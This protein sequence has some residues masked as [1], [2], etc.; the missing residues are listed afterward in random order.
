[1]VKK[2]ITRKPKKG[3]VRKTRKIVKKSRRVMKGGTRPEGIPE[4]D[5]PTAKRLLDDIGKWR[6]I[7]CLKY[8]NGSVMVVEDSEDVHDVAS[9]DLIKFHKTILENVLY[10]YIIFREPETGKLQI[11]LTPFQTPEIGTKHMCLLLGIDEDAEVIASGELFRKGD[12]VSYSCMSSLFFSHMLKQL[13][14]TISY[15]EKSKVNPRKKLIDDAREYYEREEVLKYMKEV[16]PK[17]YTIIYA[18]KFESSIPLERKEFRP[19]EFCTL[20]EG[21]RPSCLRYVTDKEC[22]TLEEHPGL[23]YCEAGVDFCSNLD[24]DTPPREGIPEEAYVYENKFDNE[25]A[26][27]F[28]LSQ[29]KTPLPD[30]FRNIQFAKKV[31]NTSKIPLD[32]LK[33]KSLA[34][35]KPL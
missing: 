9:C 25:K 2:N 31:A 23:G 34:W 26:N 29:G 16:L 14:P 27:E 8:K 21:E 12:V 15:R 11:A 17:Q 20:P 6:K 1:M 28:L 22:E 7:S 13:Y 5:F 10:Q 30:K 19:E 4:P 3:K 24:K 33:S 35:P 32:V 18:E